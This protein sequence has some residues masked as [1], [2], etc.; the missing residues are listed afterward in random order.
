MAFLHLLVQL[1]HKLAMQTPSIIRTQFLH[2]H[3]QLIQLLKLLPFLLQKSRILNGP[4]DIL[5][6]TL[7]RVY[8]LQNIVLNGSIRPIQPLQF[9]GLGEECVLV[10]RLTREKFLGLLLIQYRHGIFHLDIQLVKH[11]VQ[12]LL[13]AGFFFHI[14]VQK[15]VAVEPPGAH[16]NNTLHRNVVPVHIGHVSIRPLVQEGDSQLCP[17]TIGTGLLAY[18][19]L[20]VPCTMRPACSRPET[21]LDRCQYRRLSRTI[22]TV[23]K[24]HVAT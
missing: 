5:T 24:V 17:G 16:G 6:G 9:R 19:I 12:I 13:G 22:L 8:L 20:Q 23:D 15:F 7:L 21:H 11:G 18:Q 3:L 10:L 2:L 14:G 1:I 4:T